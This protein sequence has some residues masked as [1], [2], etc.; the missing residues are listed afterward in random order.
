MNNVV[1]GLLAS[2]KAMVVIAVSIASF[3]ALY[4]G[5]AQW[6]QIESLLKWL[7]GTWLVSQ[8][9]EDS[10]KDFGESKVAAAKA[11]IPPPPPVDV[12]VDQ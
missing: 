7:L 11:S 1:V 8:G 12:A 4:L 3:V 9:I 6:E 5:K 10:A 2:R